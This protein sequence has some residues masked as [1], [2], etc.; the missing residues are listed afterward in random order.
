MTT[1]PN[2]SACPL[3]GGANACA[4]EV[5][6]ATGKAQPPCWCTR[7]TFTP[8]L[9]ASVPEA[10]RRKACICAGCAAAAA[11]REAQPAP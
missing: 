7:A 11:Q 6:R 5:Q 8:A 2:P 3:C 1:Q 9:L 4:M 10:S